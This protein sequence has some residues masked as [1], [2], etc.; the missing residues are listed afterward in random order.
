VLDWIAGTFAWA[1]LGSA[2]IEILT[3]YDFYVKDKPLP[4]RYRRAGFWLLR[5]LVAW[6]EPTGFRTTRCSP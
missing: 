3:I 5:A 1:V 6:R 2:L 4:P